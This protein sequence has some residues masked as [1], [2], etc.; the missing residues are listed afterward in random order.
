MA[1]PWLR[2]PEAQPPGSSLHVSAQRPLAQRLAISSAP[3]PAPTSNGISSPI[4]ASATQKLQT[5]PPGQD[6]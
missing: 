1:Y 2:V 3:R 6:A 5:R 4:I